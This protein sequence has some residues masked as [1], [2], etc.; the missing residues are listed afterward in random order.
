MLSRPGAT[1][2]GMGNGELDAG[3]AASTEGSSHGQQQHR[4]P[5]ATLT[6]AVAQAVSAGRAELSRLQGLVDA[7]VE[8]IE[9]LATDNAAADARP[10]DHPLP[11]SGRPET[12]DVRDAFAEVARSSRHRL[13]QHLSQ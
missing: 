9:K 1:V 4:E 6:A 11:G 3:P 7:A 10:A 8:Q 5:R 13:E 12:A 2:R